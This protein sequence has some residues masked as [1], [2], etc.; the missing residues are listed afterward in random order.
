MRKPFHILA[1][2]LCAPLVWC[3]EPALRVF[4]RPVEILDYHLRLAAQKRRSYT[5]EMIWNADSTH[6]RRLRVRVPAITECDPRLGFE[7]RYEVLEGDSIVSSGI[8]YDIYPSGGDAAFSIV[9]GVEPDGARV[10]LGASSRSACTAVPFDA[11]T[12]AG[13]GYVADIDVAELRNEI[14]YR[15]LPEPRYVESSR[16]DT[17]GRSEDMLEA[18]WTY[19]DRDM[20]PEASL[21]GGAYTL[22]TVSDG[23]GGYD[24]VYIEGADY[25]RDRWTKGRVKGHI[26]PSGFINHYDLVWYDAAG[27]E[28][29]GEVSADVEL[30]GA[31]LRLNFPL[32]SASI[33]FRRR[34]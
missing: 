31:V 2:L 17:I 10:W 24:I 23:R 12:P 26:R 6:S 5:A 32:Y 14:R 13:I 29:S 27:R 20:R 34:N 28:I 4:D 11:D 16:L 22:A 25:G 7:T 8:V 9:L 21:P 33:R 30:G 18:Y 3:G 15:S 19:L 1:F